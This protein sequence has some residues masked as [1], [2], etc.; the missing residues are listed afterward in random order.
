[1]EG[2][3]ARIGVN[4]AMFREVNERIEELAD[5]FDIGSQPLHLVC[6]C[7]NAQC[8][9]HIQMMRSDYEELRADARRFG[10]HPGHALPDVETV[11][12]RRQG[13]DVVE[14]NRGQPEKI[15]RRTDPRR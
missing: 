6:E 13:Y 8:V 5:E 15:A 1:V 7:G 2:R 11:V 10:V 9:E 4:E 3:E 14:K 12:G